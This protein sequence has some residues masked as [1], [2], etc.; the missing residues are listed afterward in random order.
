MT[1][2][3]QCMEALDRANMIRLERARIKRQIHDGEATV[4]DVLEAEPYV[5]D[6]MT[7]HQL[8]TAQERWGDVRAR[9]FLRHLQIAELRRVGDLTPRQRWAIVSALG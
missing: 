6:S 8:L 2:T 4:A 5:C 3:A 1:A 7:I 9:K